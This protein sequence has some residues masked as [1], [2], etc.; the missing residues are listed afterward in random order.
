MPLLSTSLSI[1]TLLSV[2]WWIAWAKRN[3]AI[4][5]K[6]L[7][8]VALLEVSLSC[9]TSALRDY[10]PQNR[11]FYPLASWVEQSFDPRGERR[12]FVSGQRVRS[13]I[14]PSSPQ[15]LRIDLSL[16][17]FECH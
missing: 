9:P 12:R 17:D 11:I 8:R 15:E 16:P 1:L 13:D 10:I 7:G 6:V 4:F 14:H 2:T 3:G 5:N